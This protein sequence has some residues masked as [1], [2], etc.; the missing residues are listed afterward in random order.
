LS[1]KPNPATQAVVAHVLPGVPFA[2]VAGERPGKPRTPDP[3]VAIEIAA[4]L[5]LLPS[6]CGFVGDTGVDMR[7]ATGAGM[8]AVGVTWG[9][10]GVDDLQAGGA[11]VIVEDPAKILHLVG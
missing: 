4:F 1:N 2:F 6:Q 11:T 3:T 7:T 8:T 5:G 10:R 9:Y